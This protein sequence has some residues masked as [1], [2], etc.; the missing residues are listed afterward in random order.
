MQEEA[1]VTSKGQ[2]TIPNEIRKSL[3]L[4]KG[5]KI[6]FIERSGEVIIRHKIK[7]PMKGLE[8]LRKQLPVI[9]RKEIDRMIKEGKKG[10]SK[11]G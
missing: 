6:I 4:K 10:W 1:T 8:S 5:E 11:F 3:G 2:V 7:N 9:S